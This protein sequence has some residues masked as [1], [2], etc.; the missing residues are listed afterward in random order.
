MVLKYDI[1]SGGHFQ[2]GLANLELFQKANIAPLLFYTALEFR[3]CIER[4]L[5]EY[6]GLMYIEDIPKRIE[7]IYRVKELKN[8]ILSIEPRFIKKLEFINIYFEALNLPYRTSILDLD[9]LNEF[10]GKVGQ[11]V[12]SNKYPEKTSENSEWWSSFLELLDQIQKHLYSI[13]NNSLADFNFNQYGW[14]IFESFDSGEFSKDE[15]I[16]KIKADT[17]KWV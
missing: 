10:Y 9:L 1:T 8:E 6:L 15:L 7:K 4:L 14:E 2:R 3:C 5:I 17:N 11:Y 16:E 13:L 12:H